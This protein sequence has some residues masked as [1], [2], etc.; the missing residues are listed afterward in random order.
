MTTLPVYPGCAVP[1]TTPTRVVPATPAT[2]AALIK[3]A[4]PG[5]EIQLASGDYGIVKILNANPASYVKITSAP[6]AVA[7]LSGILVAQSSFLAFIGLMIES[8]K[9]ASQTGLVY[10]SGSHDLVIY[11][12]IVRSQADVSSWTQAD[13][14]AKAPVL[15]IEVYARS[16]IDQHSISITNNIIYGI[17][18]PL[19]VNANQMLIQG[20]IIDNFGDDAMDVLGSD[21]I[22]HGNKVTNSHNLANGN[23]NDFIQMAWAYFES[24]QPKDASGKPITYWFKNWLIDG[25][26]FI[27]KTDPNLPFPADGVWISPGQIAPDGIQGI[28]IS[29]IDGFTITNNVIVIPDA[30][31]IWGGGINGVIVNNTVLNTIGARTWIG[32]F[33]NGANL[34]IRNNLVSC[35]E[36]GQLTPTN[37]SVAPNPLTYTIGANVVQD[38]N[39]DVTGVLGTPGVKPGVFVKFDPI[40][41]EYDLHLVPSSPAIGAGSALQAPPIDISGTTRNPASIDLG[42]YTYSSLSNSGSVRTTQS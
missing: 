33:T 36:T 18:T 23:H 34:T 5:D 30:N 21:V 17:L 39:M 32:N 42:A 27:V 11:G 40:N 2:L 26:T 29:L 9:L 20:N 3:A 4:Q 8:N 16:T 35:F 13:W 19:G 14:I 10:I 25:N 1:F 28:G 37:M 6:G 31:G 41:C 22:F 12:N 15:G 24:L 38:H 7:A